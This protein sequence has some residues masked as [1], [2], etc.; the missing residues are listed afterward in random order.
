MAVMNV[1]NHQTK[2]LLPQ[3][4]INVN[5]SNK[6]GQNNNINNNNKINNNNNNI[7]N[8][9]NSSLK[10]CQLNFVDLN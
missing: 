10:K 4:N 2:Q 9:N 6:Q 1:F 7:N 5:S 3:L 8:Y